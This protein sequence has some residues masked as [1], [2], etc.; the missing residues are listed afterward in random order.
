MFLGQVVI[1]HDS[2][3]RVNTEKFE[4]TPWNHGILQEKSSCLTWGNVNTDI[5]WLMTSLP[6]QLDWGGTWSHAPSA[7]YFYNVSL[8]TWP[9]CSKHSSASYFH[10]SKGKLLRVVIWPV[11]RNPSAYLPSLPSLS[12]LA[13][14]LPTLTLCS[15]PKLHM[16][17][18]SSLALRLTC[19]FSLPGAFCL[20]SWLSLTHFCLAFGSLLR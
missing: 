7:Q 15:H 2:H 19:V 17:P 14:P 11:L 4:R 3:R 18:C 1:R 16:I 8:I 6:I 5:L 20:F 9:L 10:Q 13:P 12:T